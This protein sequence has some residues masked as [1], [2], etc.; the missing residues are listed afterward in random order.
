MTLKNGKEDTYYLTPAKD[1]LVAAKVEVFA[2]G[3]GESVNENALKL[4]ASDASHVFK[5]RDGKTLLERIQKSAETPCPAE[6]DGFQGELKNTTS[7]DSGRRKL[8]SDVLLSDKGIFYDTGDQYG[9][10]Y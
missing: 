6:N 2:V 5:I 7:V 1:K 10:E 3:V 4:I 9:N 8:T